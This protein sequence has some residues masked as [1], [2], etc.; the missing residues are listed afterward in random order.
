M[1][2]NSFLERCNVFLDFLHH[3]CIGHLARYCHLGHESVHLGPCFL[4]SS[5]VFLLLH[6][7][8]VHCL[9]RHRSL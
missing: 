2:L 1:L 6:N 5:L 7:S 4:Y 8:A 3:S 9:Q